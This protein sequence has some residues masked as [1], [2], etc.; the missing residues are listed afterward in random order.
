MVEQ[1][2]LFIPSNLGYVL[3]NSI[4]KKKNNT[5]KINWQF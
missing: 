4:T 2:D 5:K 1:A 3:V